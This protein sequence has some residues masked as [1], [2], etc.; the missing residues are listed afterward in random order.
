MRWQ[1]SLALATALA[2]APLASYA[3]AKSHRK[4]PSPTPLPLTENGAFVFQGLVDIA[5]LGR[6]DD[7]SDDPF[8]SPDLPNV[9]G[10]PFRLLLP[11]VSHQAAGGEGF[12]SWSYDLSEKKMTVSFS[13]TNLYSEDAIILR[14]SEKVSGHYVGSNAFGVKKRITAYADLKIAVAIKS[15]PPV[16]DSQGH[17]FLHIYSKD[18]SDIDP[19]RGRAISTSMYAVFSGTIADEK[20]PY[21]CGSDHDGATIDDPTDVYTAYCFV[22]VDLNSIELIG[23]D[24][25]VLAHWD[26]D[27]AEARLV[28]YEEANV[29][30]APDK[31]TVASLYP[32]RAVRSGLPGKASVRCKVGRSGVP[33]DCSAE[34]ESPFGYGF[35]D[36]ATKAARF[37]KFAPRDHA[38]VVSIPVEFVP[39][40]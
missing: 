15:F 30:A 2:C 31:D 22:N 33:E 34:A 29:I 6:H 24:K 17:S 8:K 19:E 18:L 14:S 13:P 11:V 1:L 21:R 16:E 5:L 38:F 7:S 12:P 3:A 4:A 26:K 32:E 35:G 40:H 36:A 39:P 10:A 37:F 9:S 23:P 27:F 25:S 20:K 28:P